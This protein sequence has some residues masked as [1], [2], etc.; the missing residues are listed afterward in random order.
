MASPSPLERREKALKLIHAIEVEQQE[1]YKRAD[2]LAGLLAAVPNGEVRR[3]LQ[4]AEAKLKEATYWLDQARLDAR[5]AYTALAQEMKGGGDAE[6]A[7][8]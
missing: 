8:D 1:A 5:V 4:W 7:L 6:V 2:A 3:N